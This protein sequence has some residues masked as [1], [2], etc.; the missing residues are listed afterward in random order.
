VFD[1]LNKFEKIIF[2]VLAV[3]LVLFYSYSA[4]VRPA[5]TQYHRGIFVIIT[6]VLVFLLYKSKHKWM[7]VGDYLLI[8]LSIFSIGY[9]IVNFE[10]INY[11]TG[12]E[13][14]FDMFVAMIGV[15][16]GIEL[17]RRVV[18]NVFVI[19]GGLLLLYGV[20]G[21]LAPDLF[22]HAGDTFP[23]VCT[24][25]F[26]KSDGVF[27]IMANVLATYVILFVLFGAFLEKSGA[28]RFF[29]DFPM[30]AVGHRVGGP[31]KVSVIASGLFGSISGSAIANTVSTGT[32][33]IPMMKKAGFRP[34][35]AGGIEPAASISGMFMPPIM[36]AGGFIMSELTG[37]PYSKIM[38]VAIFPA[39]MYVFSVFIM[40]HYEAKIHNIKG[41]KS[42]HSAMG[43]LRK[44]WAFTLPLIVIT[45]FMLT[46]YSPAYAAILG[47]AT[48]VAVSYKDKD[49]RIDLTV[50]W[51]AA[52]LLIGQLLL[53]WIITPMMGEAGNAF[54]EKI[55]SARLLVLYGLV[56]AIIMLFYRRS[57]GADIKSELIHFVEASRVGAE[58]SLK[59]GAVV[60]VI[61]IIIGVL[62]Y[63]GLVLTF[64]DIVIELAG[65]SLVLTIL[66]I[67]LASLVLGMGV[68]VTAAYLITAVV[69]VPALIH[70]GVNEIAAHMIVYWL[71]Q[72]SNITP[73]VCIAAFAGATIAKANMWKTAFTSFKF[74]KFLYLGPFLFGYV[75]GFSLNGSAMDI[76][77]AFVLILFGTYA[78]S[79]LLSG[80]WFKS[81]KG[82]FKKAPAS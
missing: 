77:K 18:G 38:L 76:I 70:L 55:F 75:P 31:A 49:T 29:I 30:A 64:A 82:M 13:T 25:I 24:S 78:Y 63:S 47:L 60:G 56:F 80:I 53:P 74:A 50:V 69:A 44:Q 46:G 19:L 36:G 41:E 1:K 72:D 4:V 59:I 35:V 2:D 33:T 12:A 15:L 22:A 11:R 73:P 54:I 71:S 42:E 48:C 5:A 27:G 34:H 37:V 57:R 43:I 40:V 79:W 7:R 6:Y 32:F 8:F 58:N 62:T 17:A 9:W 39:I 68:P 23:G 66:L 45:V 3:F 10:A 28:Q 21:D 52:S 67:A 16:I 14:P 51:I 26:Y 65:G 61:G 20:Y 81:L